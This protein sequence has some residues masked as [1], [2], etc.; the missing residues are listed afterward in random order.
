MNGYHLP[1]FVVKRAFTYSV[2]CNLE[3]KPVLKILLVHLF[4]SS[5]M[6]RMQYSSFVQYPRPQ[7]AH[8]DHSLPTG[9]RRWT[10][11]YLLL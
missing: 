3:N 11:L 7:V 4:S 1:N 8:F 5:L 6:Y 10:R 9:S 2:I